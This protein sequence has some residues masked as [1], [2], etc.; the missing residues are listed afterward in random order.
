MVFDLI[1]FVVGVGAGAVMGAAAGVL[2]SL[3][4]TADVQEKLRKVSQ[5]VVI[6]KDFLSNSNPQRSTRL[7]NLECDLKEIHEEIRRMYTKTTR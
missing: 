4:R 3:E 1:S 2:H 6:M 5:E 7:D